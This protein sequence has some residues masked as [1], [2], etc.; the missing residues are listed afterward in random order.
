MRNESWENICGGWPWSA[1]FSDR[2]RSRFFAGG[3]FPFAA[4]AFGAKS[5]FFESGEL[6]LAILSLLSEGP[7]HGYQLM[8]EL[9]ERSGGVY[10]ASAGSVYPIL[11]QLEDEE[12]ICA[13]QQGGKRVYTLTD[14]GRKEL[15][16]DP[17]TV[18]RIWERAEECEDWGQHMGPET[19]TVLPLFGPLVKASLRAAGRGGTD[20]V[21]DILERTRRELDKI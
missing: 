20:R 14:A 7:K 8:K 11:Q 13:V 17:D 19:L 16:R 10:R 6:R 12:M 21:R 18:R 5:R 3:S 1:A 15:E 4:F 2:R 9:E